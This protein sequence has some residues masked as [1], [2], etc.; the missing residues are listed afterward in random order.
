MNFLTRHFKLTVTLSL[1]LLF[2][3]PALAEPLLGLTL[4]K[5]TVT[6]VQNLITQS[7]ALVIEDKP[8]FRTGR[9]IRIQGGSL[10]GVR[11]Y[12][13]GSFIFNPYGVL[14]RYFLN[15]SLA[16]PGIFYERVQAVSSD[17]GKPKSDKN[18]LQFAT[19]FGAVTL[20]EDRRTNILMEDWQVIQC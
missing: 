15:Y 14:E 16:A 11:E 4:L 5:S 3:N 1:G 12:V 20:S 19:E 18:P 2:I 8:L 17:Y 9:V 6:D 7:G 10:P 13:K